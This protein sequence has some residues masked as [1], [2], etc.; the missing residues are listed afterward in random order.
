MARRT[1][2]AVATATVTPLSFDQQLLR[3]ASDP[4]VKIERLKEIAELRD[5]IRRSDAEAEFNVAMAE[6]QAEM[7]PVEADAKNDSTHSKYATHYAVDRKLRPFYS[8]HGFTLSFGTD[9]CPLPDHTRVICYVS[10]G[11]YTRRYQYDVAISTK[12][13]KGNDVMTPTHAG[14]SG[15]TYGRRYLELAIFNVTIGK[16][17]DG[18]AAAGLKFISPEQL[19]ELT[20]L[21]LEAEAD[22]RRFCTMLKIDSMAALQELRFAEAKALLNIKLKDKKARAAKAKT[23]SDFPGDRPLA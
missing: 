2:K 19:H 20:M 1:T 5:K 11:L 23:A 6:C 10:R 9:D 15:M 14:G 21:A 17:D 18:N 12:G 4:T 3:I 13:P 16:D 7:R 8:K 22:V